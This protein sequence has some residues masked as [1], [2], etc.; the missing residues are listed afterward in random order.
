MNEFKPG[1]AVICT[2]KAIINDLPMAT[3]HVVE[4]CAG[5]AVR[6]SGS[7]NWWPADCFL[8]VSPLVANAIPTMGV[9]S[10]W[11]GPKHCVDLAQRGE[12]GIAANAQALGLD[13]LRLAAASA[14]PYAA[15]REKLLTLLGCT[16]A[17]LDED[18]AYE[19]RRMPANQAARLRTIAALRAELDRP[20]EPRFPNEGRSDRVYRSNSR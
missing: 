15:H 10:N 8:L 2:S 9:P 4:E 14:D 12:D 11:S 20:C 5:Y 3:V 6:V 1:D 18:V 13:L 16:P 19:T 17:G 7:P